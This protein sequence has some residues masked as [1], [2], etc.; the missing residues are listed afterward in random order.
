M[1]EAFLQVENI[2]GGFPCRRII[3][4]LTHSL[5]GE[6]IYINRFENDIDVKV[7]LKRNYGGIDPKV[8]VSLC[9]LSQNTI[10]AFSTPVFAPTNPN[11]ITVYAGYETITTQTSKIPL[12]F[13]GDILWAIPVSPRPDIWF[14]ITAIENFFNIN[15]VVSWG[16]KESEKYKTRIDLV[17]SICKSV[18]FSNVDTFQ[19]E[20]LKNICDDVGQPK[21]MEQ[22]LL[23]PSDFEFQGTFG[24]FLKEIYSFG[25]MTAIIKE[26]KITLLPCSDDITFIKNNSPTFA[27]TI[28]SN[29]SNPMIGNPNPNPTGVNFTM[30]FNTYVEPLTFV[31]LDSKIYTE[32]NMVYW[33]QQVQYD[34]HLRGQNFYSHIV[35]RR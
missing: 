15:K 11:K 24:S 23:N 2:G 14:S 34:L 25:R 18:G 17:E 26:S 7:S 22:Y 29:S 31:Y 19:F 20:R 21:R 8:N 5:T 27:T 16:Q 9:N 12:L 6:R 3:V 28:S 4:E 30:L 35:A 13:T 33:V 1:A 10:K 32:F